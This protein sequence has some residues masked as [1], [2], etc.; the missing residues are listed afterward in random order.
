MF[1]KTIQALAQ[2][3]Q[4]GRSDNSDSLTFDFLQQAEAHATIPQNGN[5]IESQSIIESFLAILISTISLKQNKRSAMR[6]V[7]ILQGYLK[8]D[9]KIFKAFKP[10]KPLIRK[11]ELGELMQNLDV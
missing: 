6:S 1:V 10:N 3:L 2:N 7:K 5:G 9:A 8:N 4:H 11:M